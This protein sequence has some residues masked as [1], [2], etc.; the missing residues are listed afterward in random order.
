MKTMKK[1]LGFMVL[2][3]MLTMGM[4]GCN[5]GNTKDSQT[6]G[7]AEQTGSKPSSDS[8]EE[9]AALQNGITK[10]DIVI[11][12]TTDVHSKLTDYIGY[13]GAADAW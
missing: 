5:S 1:F 12:F 10:D 13:D 6:G 8:E 11:L 9:N 7:N 4:A 3:I 2:L